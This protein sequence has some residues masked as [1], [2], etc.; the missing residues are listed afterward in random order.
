MHESKD[1]FKK[2]FKNSRTIFI[3]K[4]M[5]TLYTVI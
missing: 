5:I 2:Y 3:L 1:S 4:E